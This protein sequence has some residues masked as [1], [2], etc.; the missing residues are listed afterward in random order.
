MQ[1]PVGTKVDWSR[2]TADQFEG[3]VF[4]LFRTAEGYENENW[5]MKTNAPDRGRDI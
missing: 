2:L 3:I 4:E 5:L 1:S